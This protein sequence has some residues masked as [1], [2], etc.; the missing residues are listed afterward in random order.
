MQRLF[1]LV[2][3]PPS[4]RRYKVAKFDVFRARMYAVPYYHGRVHCTRSKSHAK[5]WRL[6]PARVII[7]QG[8][9]N[10]IYLSQLSEIHLYQFYDS[11]DQ[12]GIPVHGPLTRHDTHRNMYLCTVALNKV[13]SDVFHK[14][15]SVLSHKQTQL[16][17]Q[18]E[19]V[20]NL[21]ALR[22]IAHDI[23]VPS[24]L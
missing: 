1:L 15:Q 9:L 13:K 14:S 23:N 17:L 4:E 16:C 20:S 19:S 24:V 3:K 12:H 21:G 10:K 5:L 22:S 6:V 8:L 18:T 7:R 11:A 2:V